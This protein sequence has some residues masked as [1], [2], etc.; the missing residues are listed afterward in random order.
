MARFSARQ[1][2][3]FMGFWPPFLGAGIK[4]QEFADD[5]TRVVVSHRPNMLTKT[6][7][8]LPSVARS[9]P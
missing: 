3:R 7:W 9:P 2:K 6:P 4:I 1:L 5:G 8:V